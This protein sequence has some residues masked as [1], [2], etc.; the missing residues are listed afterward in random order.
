[1]FGRAYRQDS[2]VVK[3]KGSSRK[4][5]I[6]KKYTN[7]KDY[8]S[9]SPRKSFSTILSRANTTQ[10]GSQKENV[11][12]CEDGNQELDD[13][14]LFDMMIAEDTKVDSRSIA[15]KPYRLTL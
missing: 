3:Q 15:V 12:G 6:K 13:S 8:L 7:I 14:D 10:L 1:M 4:S 5:S 9:S 2:K 11:N